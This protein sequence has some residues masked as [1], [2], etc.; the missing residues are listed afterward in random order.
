MLWC[1]YVHDCMI[2]L[3]LSVVFCWFDDQHFMVTPATLWC[4]QDVCPYPALRCVPMPGVEFTERGR[5]PLFSGKRTCQN[6]KSVESL[7]SFFSSNIWESEKFR[8]QC[9]KN[10]RISHV[11][12]TEN[13]WVKELVDGSPYCTF[14]MSADVIG[15]VGDAMSSTF[16]SLGGF[17]SESFTE[18]RFD[19]ENWKPWY[20]YILCIHEF[21]HEDHQSNSA[22]IINHFGW[23][24]LFLFPFWKTWKP[25]ANHL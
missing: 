13:Q 22:I 11:F 16:E 9:C 19:L 23:W 25:K 7:P 6:I 3:H 18:I 8:V 21:H 4:M 5:C 14:K 17:D 12:F 15:A 20:L 24:L 10:P 2:L 1:Y